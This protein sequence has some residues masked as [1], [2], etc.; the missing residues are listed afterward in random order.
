MDLRERKTKRAIRDTFL[1]L[2]AKKPLE[3]MTV[4]ELSELAEI[5]KATFYLHFKDIYDL[6]EQLQNE[7]VQDIMS[8]VSQDEAA[9]ADMAQMTKK[10]YVAFCSHQHLIDILF[11]GNQASALPGSIEQG[12]KDHIY[13][14]KPEAKEDKVFNVLLTYQI[15]GGFYAYME[16]RRLLGDESILNILDE[17]SRHLKSF[18]PEKHASFPN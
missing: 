5:S 8:A 7:V 18:H 13:K 10:L 14:I 1:Q 3:R 9:L 4:K 17:L 2:R 6:S 12:I 15:Q 11:S 16:N